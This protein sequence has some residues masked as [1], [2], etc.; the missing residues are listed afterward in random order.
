MTLL[1][2][3]LVLFASFALWLTAKRGRGRV[4]GFFGDDYARYMQVS[5]RFVPFL[6]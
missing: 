4:F 3:M 1:N 6:F 5:K 2:T